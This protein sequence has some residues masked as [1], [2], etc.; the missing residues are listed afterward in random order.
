MFDQAIKATTQEHLDIHT[1]KEHLVIL[2][3]GSAAMIVQTSAINFGLLSEEEQDAAIYGYA[4][5][6][7]SLSFPI[8]ILIRSVRKDI[9]Q[10]LE[11]V[12]EQIQK[13]RSQK[14]KEQVVKYRSFIKSLVKD[15]K[16][17][18]KKFY[19]VIPYSTYELGVSASSFNPFAKSP[20]KPSYEDDYI[21]NKAKLTLYPR[22]DHLVRQLARIGLQAKQLSTQEIVT[23]F[24]RAYN[25]SQM[26]TQHLTL[27]EDYETTAV[28]SDDKPRGVISPP[29]VGGVPAA[30]GEGVLP[31]LN[32]QHV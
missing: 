12:D 22:R 2:K 29:S 26:G 23:L 16:V 32:N 13:T 27:P 31:N 4:G 25:P 6:L 24:Y 8:Q 17:L 18:E 11:Y 5:L 15:N 10:Y 3:D 20:Q 1:I 19:I 7:N 21:I 9:T 30:V 28:S 14:I